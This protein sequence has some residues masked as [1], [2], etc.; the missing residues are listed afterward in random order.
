MAEL[1]SFSRIRSFYY[2][3]LL[4]WRAF[5]LIVANPTLIF[6]SLLPIGLTT[7]L[8]VFAISR[9]QGMAKTFFKE[10]LTQW[11]W[12]PEGAIAWIATLV[13]SLLL[14]IV[15][16]LTFTFLS[17][18]IAAPFNDFLAEKTEGYV[19]PAL[20]PVPESSWK[21]KMHL[22]GIDLLKTFAAT[23]ASVFAL[24][25]SWIPVVNLLS[26]GAAFLLITFQYTSY[27]QTRRGI[28]LGQGVTFL[29][30]HIFACLGFGATLALLYSIPFVSCVTLPL[31][32][33]GGT[34]LVS[35]TQDGETFP[36][37]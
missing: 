14:I 24:L 3:L 13:F 10:A 28:S 4:P 26:A 6:W 7:T 34:L 31:A 8:Y 29:W 5:K 36:L 22:I 18:M 20:S 33:V 27:P 23:G 16:A 9:L 2:G 11:G 1:L 37:K 12:N 15:S 19:Q 30:K 25:F 17:S 35:R 21:H 32:V